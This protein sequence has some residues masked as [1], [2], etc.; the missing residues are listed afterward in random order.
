MQQIPK[1]AKFKI[2]FLLGCF[3]SCPYTNKLKKIHFKSCSNIP[4]TVLWKVKQL[5]AS[6]IAC[7]CLSFI[8]MHCQSSR[9]N[10][11]LVTE[12]Y[13]LTCTIPRVTQ[14]SHTKFSLFSTF[15]KHQINSR[16]NDI[17]LLMPWLIYPFRYAVTWIESN[18]SHG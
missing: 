5:S 11:L 10:L 1:S 14:Y 4:L 6:S 12:H 15:T 13:I 8:S 7:T 18:K 2:A 16:G 17:I 3:F 9:R